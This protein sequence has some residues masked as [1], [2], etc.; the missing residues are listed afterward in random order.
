MRFPPEFLDRLRAHFLVSEVVGKRVPLKRHGREFHACCPFHKE[1]SPS[2]TVNDEKGFYHCFGCG[3]HGDAIGFV[4]EYENLSYPEA[5]E[6]LAEEAGFAIPV[7][8]ARERQ[9]AEQA[10][11]L[12][13]AMEA[14]SAWYAAQLDTQDA[15]MVRDYLAGR[16]IDRATIAQFRIGYAPA[17]RGALRTHLMGKGFAEAQLIEAGLL[18]PSDRGQPFARFTERLMFPITDRAGRV[19]AFGGRVLPGATGP[20]ANAK[21]INSPDTPLFHKGQVLY[22]FATAR[23]AAKDTNQIVVAEGYM[24]VI[25]L[26]QGG[27][28]QA[29]APLGTAMTEHHL[30][31]LWQSVPEPILCLDGDTAGQRAMMRAAEL[32]L[33][34]MQAGQGLRFAALPAGQDPDSLLRA[35][36][37]EALRATLSAAIP[38]SEALWNHH[39]AQHPEA[40]PEA[41]ARL[42][43]ALMA[44]AE[45][46]ADVSVRKHFRQYFLD[47]LR[48]AARPV[49][50]PRAAKAPWKPG[51][52]AAPTSA[53]SPALRAL[54]AS[55]DARN[56][57]GYG[58]RPVLMTLLCLIPSL[59]LESEVEDDL[60][61]LN[62][63]EPEDMQLLHALSDAMH[64][65]ESAGDD[66]ACAQLSAP[67]RALCQSWRDKA[68]E[69]LLRPLHA[70]ARGGN[71]DLPRLH[72]RVLV[73]DM[74][75]DQLDK[76]AR[77]HGEMEMTEES[78]ARMMEMRRQL[79]E[80][81]QE[82][83]RLQEIIAAL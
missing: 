9:R 75:I 70:A 12:V 74:Q 24:D 64:R 30:K 46:A 68:E 77:R 53:S 5:I 56:A 49:F 71:R 27:I 80:S 50:T 51:Q 14:A 42:E 62:F 81:H 60:H 52:A 79:L 82:R 11:T 69:L 16:G 76:E 29:V 8:D 19:I 36:G 13:D 7:M 73:L 2:F 66:V 48:A 31:A 72:W 37:P 33:P 17:D 22:N 47:Q 45:T 10:K 6:R 67:M 34:M 26:A 25:A 20:M 23:K 44:V 15:M 83:G 41:R 61:R 1:K 40:S 18:I 35:Q 21:Y 28:P 39:S 55:G 43:K 59:L 65:N 3:V 4:K 78:Q 32:A 58:L 38:L 63:L 57:V 54:A